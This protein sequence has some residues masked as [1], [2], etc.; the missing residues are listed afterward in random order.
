[1]D[2][3]L[4]HHQQ[5]GRLLDCLENRNR[6]EAHQ[7]EA[8][9]ITIRRNSELHCWVILASKTDKTDG[10]EM[11]VEVS[12][13]WRDDAPATSVATWLRSTNNGEVKVKVQL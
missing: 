9:E 2:G 10:I 5:L 7:M 8:R 12:T 3:V 13:P 6:L 1:M 4:A 11:E